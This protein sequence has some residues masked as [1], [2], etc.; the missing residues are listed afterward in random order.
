VYLHSYTTYSDRLLRV[1]SDAAPLHV[2]ATVHAICVHRFPLRRYS[3]SAPNSEPPHLGYDSRPSIL[4]F[5]AQQYFV[6]GGIAI[7]DE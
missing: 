4:V 7:D 6:V 5:R 3:A 2:V 1:Q